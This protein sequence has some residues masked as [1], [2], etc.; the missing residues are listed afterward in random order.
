LQKCSL[1]R[2]L[3]IR[4]GHCVS[5]SS[6]RTKTNQEIE[7]EFRQGLRACYVNIADKA[8]ASFGL[9]KGRLAS[10]LLHQEWHEESFNRDTVNG[11]P[12]HSCALY[13]TRGDPLCSLR[14]VFL[15]PS[16][17]TAT[18]TNRVCQKYTRCHG[19]P[20]ANNTHNE[21]QHSITK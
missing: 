13:A 6:W 3:L 1:I 9:K 21:G 16:V 11:K 4:W 14:Q 18:R 17:P 7:M 15:F 19:H 5:F 20:L 8:F 2:L 10:S 12:R